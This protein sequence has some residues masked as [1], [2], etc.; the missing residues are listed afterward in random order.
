[1]AKE[2]ILDFA[3]GFLRLWT[4]LVEGDSMLVKAVC[5]GACCWQIAGFAAAN[6]D[7]FGGGAMPLATGVVSVLGRGGFCWIWPPNF[8]DTSRFG[9]RRI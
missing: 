9:R 7:G 2:D 6:F 8:H 1:M 4:V 3:A 5:F